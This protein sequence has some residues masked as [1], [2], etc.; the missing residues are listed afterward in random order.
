MTSPFFNE[1]IKQCIRQKRPM[2]FGKLGAV[3]TDCLTNSEIQKT[4]VWGENL[5]INAGVFP[6]TQ[7]I[8]DR[9]S[10]EYIQA[11]QSL[12]AC[13][14]WWHGKDSALLDKYNPTRLISNEIDDL[15]PFYLKQDSWHYGLEEKTVLVVHPMVNTISS[16]FKK[17]SYLWP[18]A[19]IKDLI[20]VQ[21][22]YPPWLTTSQPYQTFFDCL[23]EMQHQIAKHKFDFAIVGAGAYSLLLLKF[24]KELGV[25]CVHLGGQTQLLFGIRGKRWETEYT[26]AWR[27]KNLY[28]S[29]TLWV[30]PLPADVPNNKEIV[31]NGCYW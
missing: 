14:E 24:I 15:L 22:H 7:E 1:L 28:N 12:D 16:Q 26:E 9:W 31:E 5:G 27:E 19:K 4:V 30:R 21:S 11:I 6:L 2:S 18:G 20:I 8:V 25:P 10:A 13:V 23:A 17:Y 3:E 29:S